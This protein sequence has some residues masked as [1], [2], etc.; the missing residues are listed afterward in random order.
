MYQTDFICT[1]KR[2]DSEEDKN[3]LYKIQL[4]QAFDL[5]EWDDTIV[6]TTLDDLYDLMCNDKHLKDILLK[7]YQVE[8]LMTIIDRTVN[9]AISDNISDA[10][11]DNIDDKVNLDKDIFIFY[12]LF[13]YEIFDL[14]HD[15]IIDFF[16]KG[17]ISDKKYELLIKHL[18]TKQ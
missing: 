6:N 1:Y 14:V 16:R 7:M 13:Q 11:S 4:L 8:E 3:D 5:E 9:D 10:I 18:S 15:C 2:M 17:E 12:L